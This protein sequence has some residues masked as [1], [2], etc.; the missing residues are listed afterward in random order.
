MAIV[1]NDTLDD[2]TSRMNKWWGGQGFKKI[3]K[4]FASNRKLPKYLM[5]QI[6]D[7]RNVEK[8]FKLRGIQWGN[9]VTNEDRF[10]Y[11]AALGISLYHMNQV[12]Q[13]K[14]NNLGLDEHLGIAFGARGVRGALAHYESYQNI[15][16]LTRYY[17]DSKFLSPVPK[18][19]RFVH[20]G[21]A[22]SFAHEYGHFLDFFFGQRV[23][24]YNSILW[25]SDG[26]NTSGKRIVYDAKKFPIRNKMEDILETAYWSKDGKIS[27][28]MKRVKDNAGGKEY[29]WRRNEVFAR[30][31]EQY[32]GY[33]L[34]KKGIVN[35]FLTNTKY[36]QRFY[37]TSKELEEVVPKF[38]ALLAE[39]RKVF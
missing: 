25:L 32:M 14:D 2:E 29:W 22:G 33:A 31:F 15:I 37:M 18:E 35:S 27:N 5:E 26:R 39:M 34:H 7:V 28:F 36:N 1:F 3:Y 38:E 11:L 23:E 24:T 19:K 13:F 10:N 8:V 30:L 20:T 21:G 6:E 16:N 4:E 9:W 12:L 17:D